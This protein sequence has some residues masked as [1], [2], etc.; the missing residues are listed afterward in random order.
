MMSFIETPTRRTRPAPTGLL[1]QADVGPIVAKVRTRA[2]AIAAN[3]LHHLM[4]GRVMSAIATP[5]NDNRTPA[6]SQPPTAP[7]NGG[8]RTPP[9]TAPTIAPAVFH[10]Y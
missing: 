5:I 10:T 6:T 8:T 3:A 2:T 1:R 9:A 7:S 4:P